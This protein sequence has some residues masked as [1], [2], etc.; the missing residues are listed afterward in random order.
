LER[1]LPEMLGTPFGNLSLRSAGLNHFSVLVE[2]SYRDTKADAYPDI[3]AKA[4]AF[5]EKEIGYSDILSYVMRTGPAPRTGI[6]AQSAV[7]EVPVPYPAGEG[8]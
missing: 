8:P 7:Q 1:Y 4:P 6:Q 2:A 5:F 3:L